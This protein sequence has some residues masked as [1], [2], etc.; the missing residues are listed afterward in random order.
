[1]SSPRKKTVEGR[2]GKGQG[3]VKGCSCRR[4]QCIKNYCDC[5]QS[6]AICTKF[7]R[8]T[9]CRN[10]E[11]RELVDPNS[12]AKNSNAAK[13][14]KAAA[15]SAKAAAAAAK[16]GID[17]QGKVIQVAA[18]TLALPG[19]A[20][21]TPTKF[22]LADGKPQMASSHINPIPISRP[23]ATAATPARAVKQPADTLVPVNLII[24]VLQD[25]RKER[26]LFVQPVNAALL[27]CMLIQ[28]TEAEQLGLN[29]LQ[30]CQLVLEE[31]LRGYKNI[32]EKM[33]EYSKEYC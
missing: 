3:G 6:M 1:M 25:D 7:C 26:N 15:M 20:L 17:V 29:E 22:V 13:R 8:C 28:A 32:L 10:T 18:S 31:F 5:Y 16:A 4:S 27:E 12:V 11:V 30:V 33:C 19:K 23:I 14:Q 24:P 21:M 9:G 2:R